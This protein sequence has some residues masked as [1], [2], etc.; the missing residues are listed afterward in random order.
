[1]KRLSVTKRFIMGSGINKQIRKLTKLH[2]KLKVLLEAETFDKTAA[3][4]LE[5]ILEK[6]IRS[7][8]VEV[9]SERKY[10]ETCLSII[11][12]EVKLDLVDR[13]ANDAKVM[14]RQRIAS[15]RGDEFSSMILKNR[16]RVSQIDHELSLT[17]PWFRTR[18][19]KSLIVFDEQQAGV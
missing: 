9:E 7:L 1:M 15:E 19:C 4:S 13:E 8:V 17:C 12:T 5:P 14:D 6:A 18:I 10:H 3:S 11:N 2:N 16:E